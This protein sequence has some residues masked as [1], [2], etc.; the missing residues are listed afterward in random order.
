MVALFLILTAI[1]T[2]S[3]G[4]S[5]ATGATVPNL[6]NFTG[7]LKDSGGWRTQSVT[8]VTFSLYAQQQVGVPLWQEMQEEAR[9]GRPL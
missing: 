7:T 1:S 8:G 2:F 3:Y 5:A 4:Q 6:V 9:C